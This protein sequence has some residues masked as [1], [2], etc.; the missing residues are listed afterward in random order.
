[1]SAGILDEEFDPEFVSVLVAYLVGEE[2]TT[3]G[4]I[5]HAAGGRYTRVRYAE[6]RGVEF[7]EAPTVDALAGRWDGLIDMENAV[8]RPAS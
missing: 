4:E 2:G 5:V 1:M 6:S 8:V 7:D 3:T